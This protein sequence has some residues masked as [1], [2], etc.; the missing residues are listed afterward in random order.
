MSL[1]P[2]LL[3]FPNFF[4]TVGVW[5]SMPVADAIATVVAALVLRWQLKH[6]NV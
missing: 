6:L 1:I 3:I 4:G 5:M 2:S